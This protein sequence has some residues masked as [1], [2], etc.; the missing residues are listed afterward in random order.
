MKVRHLR[1][2]LAVGV[3]ALLSVSGAVAKDPPADMDM[4]NPGAVKWGDP[5]PVL[6]KGAK[7][8]VLKGDPSKPG[9]FVMRGMFPSNYKVAPHT[10][11]QPENITVLSGALYLGFGDKMDT[12][13]GH[14]LQAGGFHYLPGKTPHYAYTKGPTVVQIHGEGPFDLVYLNPADNPDKTAKP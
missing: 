6:P 10:H 3:F 2:V 5:P 12:K 4:I 13:T 11:T 14:A 8:A 9:P 1:P 7:I